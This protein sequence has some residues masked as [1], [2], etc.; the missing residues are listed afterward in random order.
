MSDQGSP[1]PERGQGAAWFAVA[2][3]L[4]V[5]WLVGVT[6][7]VP[8]LLA[9]GVYLLRQTPSSIYS[10]T[11]DSVIDVRLLPPREHVDRPQEPAPPRNGTASAMLSE[12]SV[13]RSEPTIVA[14]DTRPTPR[15][16][17]VD[18]TSV[19]EAPAAS[20]TRMLTSDNRAAI[21][22]QKA[23]LAHIARFRRYPEEARRAGQQ[24]TVQ[25]LFA[26][27]RDGA[28]TDVQIRTSSGQSA[29]DA[30]AA[31]TIRRAQPLPRIP[32]ELP[33]RLTILAPIA[34]DM[35]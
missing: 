20:S 6:L 2:Q 21:A 19:A 34:F 23:L 18:T 9:V 22:F 15:E 17:T 7:M 4:E 10:R 35:L 33:D 11:Q 16:R 28:V 5:R 12:R 14:P 27:R 1:T 31:E 26:M 30:A 3:P 8:A 13:E 32:R 25:V 29:L 24:G